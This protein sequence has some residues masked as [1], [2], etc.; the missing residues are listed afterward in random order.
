M[1]VSSLK[2]F[3]FLWV[4][5][6]LL[7]RESLRQAEE[8]NP[9]LQVPSEGS[10]LSCCLV[11]KGTLRTLYFVPSPEEAPDEGG[12][13]ARLEEEAAN[14]ASKKTALLKHLHVRLLC[15]PE[16][17]KVLKLSQYAV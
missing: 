14:D 3:A 7:E 9:R 13:L 4:K 8:F 16:E 12:E 10:F 17:Q 1:W 5:V 2:S 11:V 15:K 6:L